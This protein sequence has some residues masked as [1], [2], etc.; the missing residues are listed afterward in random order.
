MWAVEKGRDCVV[1]KGLDTGIN[2]ENVDN[3][4]WNAMMYAAQRGNM[5][6]ITWFLEYGGDLLNSSLDDK[7]T[8]LHLAAKG[9]LI[10]I[11]MVLLKAGAYPE[12]K[13]TSGKRPLDYL[14]DRRDREKYNDC[15]SATYKEGKDAARLHQEREDRSI[16]KSLNKAM[17][18]IKKV[19][20]DDIGGYGGLTTNK[21]GEESRFEM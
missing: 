12:A 3:N 2:I 10:D 11:C 21:D 9:R 7:S 16:D 4:G 13:D 1:R 6:V 17:E 8:A 15:L 14:E 18:I 5:N 19:A 20:V